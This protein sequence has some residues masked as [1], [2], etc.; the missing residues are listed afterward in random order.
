MKIKPTIL[1][2][3]IIVVF[4]GGIQISKTLG[5]WSTEDSKEPSRITND[6]SL[7]YDPQSISGSHTFAEIGSYF[8]IDPNV[9]TQAFAID[10]LEDAINYQTKDLETVYEPMSVEVG[11]EA[12]QSFVALY[13]NLPYELIDVYLPSQAVEML[14]AQV[15]TLTSDQLTYLYDHTVSV[16]VKDV[17]SLSISTEEEESESLISGPTTIQQV[18][19]LGMSL[20]EFETIVGFKVEFTNQSVKDFCIEKGL[21]YGS[22]KTELEAALQS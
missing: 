18:L 11:N 14:K 4:F 15:N 1:A 17:S 21:S 22:I 19:D 9:L 20:S 2:L 6:E 16:S 12:V 13:L 5:Y 10:H 3:V 7:A 8:E